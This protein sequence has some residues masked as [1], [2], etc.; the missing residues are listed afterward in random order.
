[1]K[2]PRMKGVESGQPGF[3]DIKK[4]AMKRSERRSTI[5]RHKKGRKG[6]SKH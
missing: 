4:G 1:M 2:D 5:K 6:G 3:A